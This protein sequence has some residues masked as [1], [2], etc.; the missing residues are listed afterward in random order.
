MLIPRVQAGKQRRKSLK[1]KMLISYQYVQY[2]LI[3]T[4][5]LVCLCILYALEP[6][7]D[8]FNFL[9]EG[10]LGCNS[11]ETKG[12]WDTLKKILAFIHSVSHL[13]DGH[14]LFCIINLVSYNF[15]SGCYLLKLKLIINSSEN[16]TATNIQIQKSDSVWNPVKCWPRGSR[17]LWNCSVG[18]LGPVKSNSHGEPC[19]Y[20][21]PTIF[22]SPLPIPSCFFWALLFILSYL[23]SF[24]N[25][26]V[27]SF[28]NYRIWH[29]SLFHE[30]RKKRG[31]W[32]ENVAISQWVID[33]YAR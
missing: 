3:R 22:F 26:C 23:L 2:T 16:G 20:T 1:L 13:F 9:K 21:E 31:H 24:C 7:K 17:I 25:N 8:A 32:L 28:C 33:N 6:G 4:P 14:L 19:I 29:L 11:N 5:H 15:C 18:V 12:S 27:D 10:V 30:K